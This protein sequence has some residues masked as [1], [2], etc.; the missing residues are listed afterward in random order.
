M[1]S[2]LKVLNSSEHHRHFVQ[3]FKADE[4]LLNRNVASF[5]WDGLLRGDGLLVIAERQRRESL[6]SH[7]ER[8]GADVPLVRREGQLAML[9][10]NETLARFM[11]E[12]EPVWERFERVIG[13]A[14]QLASPREAEA[15]HCAYG[16]MVGVLWQTGQTDAA[17]RVEEF[18]NRLLHRGGMQ[19]YCGYPIDVFGSDFQESHVQEVLRAHTHVMP[20]G[21]Q[22]GLSAALN[23]AMDELLGTH[24]DQVRL[25]MSDGIPS[26]GAVVPEAER[27]ILWLR[28]NIPDAAEGV[29][30]RARSYYKEANAAGNSAPNSRLVAP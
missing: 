3:F 2:V 20:T 15:G 1:Q 23:R 11:V 26:A 19:L 4:P 24:A 21:P 13:E 22:A 9:D 29:L 8:L 14:L 6:A 17:F 30:A 16:E 5:L 10:A 28:S 25:S 7:L 18:W 12:G 27:A